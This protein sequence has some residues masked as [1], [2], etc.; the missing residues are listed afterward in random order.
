MGAGELEGGS[1]SRR[2]HN[3]ISLGVPKGHIP[4]LVVMHTYIYHWYPA[5][6]YDQTGPSSFHKGR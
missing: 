5:I 3:F 1:V 6:A 4:A 2:P